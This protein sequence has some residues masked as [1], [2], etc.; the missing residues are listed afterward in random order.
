MH[1]REDEI[2]KSQPQSNSL[3]KL[4]SPKKEA[5]SAQEYENSLESNNENIQNVSSFESSGGTVSI[6]NSANLDSNHELN[7]TIESLLEKIDGTYS[8]KMCNQKSTHKATLK[9]HIEGKHTQGGS[10]PCQICGKIF[11]SSHYLNVH[12]SNIHRN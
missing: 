12:M 8:C 6:Q 1:F 10:H 4:F 2:T 9:R 5:Y 3:P 7:I 11:R